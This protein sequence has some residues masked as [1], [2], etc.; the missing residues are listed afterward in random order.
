MRSMVRRTCLVAAVAAG[1][2]VLGALRGAA[3]A[4]DPP[5]YKPPPRGAPTGRVGL[6][7]RSIHPPPQIWA[8]APDHT[9]LTT[10]EQPRLY[11]Y[12][13]KPA[14]VRIEITAVRNQ[15]MKVILDESVASPAAAGVQRLDLARYGIRLEPGIEYR[16]NVSF[17]GDPKQRSNSAAIERIAASA[18]LA[19]RV[20]AAPKAEHAAVYAGEGIWYDALASLGELIEQSPNDAALR[21]QRAALLQQVGLKEAAA[22]DAKR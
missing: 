4:S 11:W 1:A 14:A 21:M 3:A 8:L 5:T 13:A 6:G 20:A 22:G 19:K 9:G 7:S 16:W 2:L 17:V 12:V 15:G 10:R 18:A